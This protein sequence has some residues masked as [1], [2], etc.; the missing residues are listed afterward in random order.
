MK[1]K[2]CASFIWFTEL[3]CRKDVWKFWDHLLL[4]VFSAGSRDEAKKSNRNTNGD[5]TVNWFYMQSVLAIKQ[6]CCA[7]QSVRYTVH[8]LRNKSSSNSSSVLHWILQYLKKLHF[9]FSFHCAKSSGHQ[10]LKIAFKIIPSLH[11]IR[12]CHCPSICWSSVI[13]ANI[14]AQKMHKAD[15]T[16]APAGA[17]PNEIESNKPTAL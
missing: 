8:V 1:S 2:L 17:F 13:S 14:F 4:V 10:K 11:D 6:Q 15:W 7:R 16:A 9:F 12:I 5:E 3:F